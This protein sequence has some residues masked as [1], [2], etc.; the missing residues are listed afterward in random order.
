MNLIAKASKVLMNAII[1]L[2]VAFALVTTAPNLFGWRTYGI[3]TGSMEPTIPT[4]SLVLVDTDIQGADIAVGD[5]LAFDIGDAN[6][7]VCTH[8]VVEND[9]EERLLT[10]KGDANDSIDATRVDYERA[11]GVERVSIPF[12]GGI[13]LA[14]SQHQLAWIGCLIA[15]LLALGIVSSL[16][17]VPKGPEK[18]KDEHDPI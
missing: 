10:T 6:H 11:I 18:E 4:G 2:V 7:T 13:L 8:R 5:V 3:L 14:V 1:A 15:A 12:V 17:D 16:A 9:R